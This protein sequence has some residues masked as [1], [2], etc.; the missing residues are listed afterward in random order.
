[1]T[2]TPR[3]I[4]RQRRQRILDATL[5]VIVDHGISRLSHRLV[6]KTAGV[7][8]S[9]TSYYFGTLEDL[10]EA[11]F[12]AAVDRDRERFLEQLEQLP[13]DVDPVAALATL[14]S[15][16]LGDSAAAVLALELCVAALRSD[17]L[18][19]LSRSWDD[20]WREML[21]PSLGPRKARLA[22]AVIPGI[23]MRGLMSVEPMPVEEITELLRDSLE[24]VPET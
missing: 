14:T 1:V 10:I 22:A 11:A 8:L 21:T 18:K 17:R 13:L 20:A 5:D 24:A 19:P 7:P 9:A 3:H 12:T 16:M 6:A 2:T 23:M 15:R 4:D